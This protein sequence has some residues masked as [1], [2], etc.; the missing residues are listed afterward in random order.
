ME[1]L[2]KPSASLLERREM[3]ILGDI[4]LDSYEEQEF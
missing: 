4:V 3:P 2:D 1:I